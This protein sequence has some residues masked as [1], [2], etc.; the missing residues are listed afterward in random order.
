MNGMD[1]R[2]GGA[3]HGDRIRVLGPII[4]GAVLGHYLDLYFHTDPWLTFALF[5]AG[6][7]WASIG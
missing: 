7:G 2:Q 1:G 5:M 3:L 6:L 4:A